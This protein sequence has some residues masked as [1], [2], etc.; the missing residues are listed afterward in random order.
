MNSSADWVPSALVVP[1]SRWAI[2]C[3]PLTNDDKDLYNYGNCHTLASITLNNAIYSCNDE[4]I[5]V[6]IGIFIFLV[7][8]EHH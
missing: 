2:S 8:E 7:L 6:V 1:D 4:D 3:K 5:Y